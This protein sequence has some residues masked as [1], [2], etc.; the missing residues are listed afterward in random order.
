MLG[1][2]PAEA[3]PKAS[4][5]AHPEL[6]FLGS[7][8]RAREIPA[9]RT[10]TLSTLTAS[11]NAQGLD[12][13]HYQGAVDWSSAASAGASFAYM[14]ATEGTT[15]VDPQFATNYAGSANAGLARGAYHFAL[16]DVSTGAAQATFFLDNGGG[17]VGDGHTAPPVLDIE[18]NPYGSADWPGWCYNKTPA[19]MT[20]WISDF[21]TTI[22]DRTNQW[23]VIYTTN[24]WWTNC[25]GGNTTIPANSPLWI[26]RI[27][28]DPGAI[29][30]GWSNYTIWQYD[31]AGTFPG[32]QDLF[33]GT[34]DQVRAFAQ[35]SV[36]DQIVT[37]Y[38]ALGGAG[39]SLGNPVGGEYPIAK[40]W[41]QNYQNGTIYYAPNTG[42]WAVTG[43]ILTRYQQLGGPGGS[44]GFPTSD[45]TGTGDG[46]G[47]YTTF[48]GASLYYSPNTGTHTV[49]GQIRTK[50]L[51]LGG[52]QTLGY[53]TTDEAVTPDGTG[54]YNHFSLAAGASVYWTPSTGAHAV[55][56]AIRD[57]WAALGW[58]TGLGYPT[59]DETVTSDGAGRYND[60]SLTAGASIY[61]SPKTAAH[62]VLGQIRDK[63]AALGRERGI[64]YPTTDEA[65]TP[66]GI[67]RYNHFS[68]DVGA[69]IYWSPNSGA[70][71]IQ[72]AIRD[73]W[74]AF[75]WEKGFG[76]PTTDESVTPNGTG[77]YNHFTNNAS[78]YWT[79]STGAW[80]VVGAI[81]DKWAS[82]G[83]ET[84]ALGYPT[85][86]EYG[87]TGGRRNNFQHGYITWFSANG[88]TQVTYS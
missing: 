14:K 24:G 13:S 66:D 6:D 46:T 29:P 67:G 69:S 53:P 8:I 61:W 73:K 72:G 3:A 31:T 77:R 84:S 28:D 70:H 79:S 85:S 54:R 1:T 16:P 81:R 37:H 40:G 71:S 32:D 36:P 42:A 26:S 49:Q 7:T 5:P 21:T 51:A 68:L 30:S 9:K 62:S 19:Q 82:L 34:V 78:V 57:K 52:L 86:D 11:S 38:T 41:A 10:R 33:N 18:Y 63:W 76:Y 20:A 55:Q 75:G 48:G 50:W 27:G 65:V 35:G 59:T 56:G 74:A 23:P 47:Q 25:T 60:F 58:E 2:G 88:T 12:V 43:P 64:G 39:S 15:Y 44:L 45:T 80:S 22:H 87:V 4:P 83:W 17:W